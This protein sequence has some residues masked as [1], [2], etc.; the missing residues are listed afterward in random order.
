M[1]MFEITMY[2]NARAALIHLGHMEKDDVKP[3]QL[4]TYRDTR[5]KET[6]LHRTKGDSQLFYGTAWYLQ[7]GVTISR[8]AVT[9]P[10]SPGN[11]EQDSKDDEPQLLAGTQTLKHSGKGAPSCEVCYEYSPVFR[12]QALSA[13]SQTSEGYCSGRCGRGVIVGGI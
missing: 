11:R 1:K 10:L 13:H 3:Y 7:S 8:A 9:S 12:F 2:N 6:H 4:L 5:R